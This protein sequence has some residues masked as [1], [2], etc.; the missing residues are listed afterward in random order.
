MSI[1][2]QILKCIKK[3]CHI[4][5]EKPVC[6]KQAQLKKNPKR[7]KK[8]KKIKFISNLVLR[9]NSL[10]KAIKSKINLKR[11][12]IMLIHHIYGEGQVSFLMEI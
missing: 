4:I 10:F 1:I 7:I 12:Y 6:L 8:K 9:E 2:S 3:N 11:I 5:V